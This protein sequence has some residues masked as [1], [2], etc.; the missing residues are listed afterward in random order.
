MVFSSFEFLLIF[1]PI[2]FFI[3]YLLAHYANAKLAIA[4]IFLAS[5]FYYGYWN[6]QYT[7]IIIISI[8]FNFLTGKAIQYYIN[9][10]KS[11]P[12]QKTILPTK[13]K[14][15]FIIGIISNLLLLFYFK[16]IDFS[17]ITINKITGSNLDL[18][19]IIL[20]IGISF[21]TFQQ[22]AYLSDIYT[23]KHT[24]TK[25]GFIEY[26]CFVCFFPQ[27]VAGPIVHHAE[28]MPQFADPKNIRINWENIYNGLFFISMGLAKKVLIA[29]RLS[30]VV[31]LAFDSYSSLSLSEAVFSS[32]AYT[33]QLYFDFSGYSDM[34]IGCALLFNIH[35]P[36]N[37]NSPYKSLSIQDFWRRWHITLSRWLR[38]YLYIPLG[39]N[40]KGN[41]RTL[42]NLF[43]T[44]LLGGIWHGAAWTF[45]LWGVLHGT[46][47]CVHRIFSRTFSLKIPKLLGWFLTFI[48]I[49]L[50]WITFRAT[51]F[52]C[53]HKF[54]IAFSGENGI[55]SPISLLKEA[56]KLD[57]FSVKQRL[58]IFLLSFLIVFALPNSNQIAT[59]NSKYKTIIIILLLIFG[60]SFAINPELKQEFIYFQ[61]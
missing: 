53:I 42:I 12:P 58:I 21:F 35:L 60:L 6:P 48:F 27:L 44:F 16:Y 51:S 43:T 36:Q 3:Y 13:E 15:I 30:P 47:L 24:N 5:L 61:F 28:M 45:I 7:Y 8:I 39:G 10:N 4:F 38:D 22:I 1:L 18:L 11:Y 29:D 25:E 41:T 31:S 17:I 55:G 49:N 40:R 20:P 34:A 59:F 56:S 46:C 54:I 26:S 14:L 37:F 50:T 33:A 57:G 52:D 23:K 9:K 2:S 19:N 32:L